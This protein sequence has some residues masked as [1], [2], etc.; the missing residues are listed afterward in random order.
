MAMSSGAA[1]RGAISSRIAWGSWRIMSVSAEAPASSPDA[2]RA[3]SRASVR[4]SE[5]S[6]PFDAP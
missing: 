2:E 6:P 5:C 4:V 3:S 1:R